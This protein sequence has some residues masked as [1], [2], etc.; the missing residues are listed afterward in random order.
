MCTQSHRSIYEQTMV[1]FHRVSVAASG[2]QWQL[3]MKMCVDVANCGN[4]NILPE[5]TPTL[6]HKGDQMQY[7]R[8]CIDA[9]R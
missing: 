7:V 4:S 9:K 2:S 1:Q 6:H 5:N 8:K 3:M